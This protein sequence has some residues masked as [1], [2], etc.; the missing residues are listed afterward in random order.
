MKGLFIS[1]KGI[2]VGA[3]LTENYTSKVLYENM[4]EN[5][6]KFVNQEIA[7]LISE[8]NKKKELVSDYLDFNLVF[9]GS[10][11]EIQTNI[12]FE[13]FIKNNS[14][15]IVAIFK[16]IKSFDTKSYIVDFIQAET[17]YKYDYLFLKLSQLFKMFDSYGIEYKVDTTPR[18]QQHGFYSD[19]T[20]TI[21]LIN[22]LPKKNYH[23]GI[24]GGSTFMSQFMYKLNN[25]ELT[26]DTC[27]QV[28]VGRK[29]TGSKEEVNSELESYQRLLDYSIIDKTTK[30]EQGPVRK[31][32]PNKKI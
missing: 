2:K 1:P 11:E 7:M 29:F 18:V 3:N 31:L 25:G 24:V 32:F 14:E 15:R 21:I 4:E 6:N 16:S 17:D 12:S 13:E 22:Y 26:L 20:S 23:I 27:P 9:C 30:E 5:T 19:E 8:F 10:I 28:E